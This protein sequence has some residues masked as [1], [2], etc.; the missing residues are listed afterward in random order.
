MDARGHHRRLDGAMAIA[1]IRRQPGF[2]GALHHRP[3]AARDDPA[4]Q[5]PRLSRGRDMGGRNPAC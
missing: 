1:A 4:G 3:P 2:D 5:R